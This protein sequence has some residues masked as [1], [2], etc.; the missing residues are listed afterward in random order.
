MKGKADFS[1]AGQYKQYEGLICNAVE[2]IAAYGGEIVDGDGNITINS[3]GT[4]KG[5]E[6]MKKIVGSDF[7]P[8]NITTFTESETHTAFIERKAAMIRNWPYVY[9]LGNDEKQSKIVGKVGVAPLPKGSVRA[10]ACLGGWSAMINKNSKHPDESWEF[11]K[12]LYGPEGQ[13]I[14]AV[15]KSGSNHFKFI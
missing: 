4:K 2:F 12:F 5:L 10:A 7:V 6:M 13:K 8:N 9:G 15:A 3:D 11:L 14:A 1:W